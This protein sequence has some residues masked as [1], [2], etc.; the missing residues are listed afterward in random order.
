MELIISVSVA[1]IL[2]A[3]IAS[4]LVV[5]GHALP[6]RQSA[7][8][9]RLRVAEVVDR[10]AG[11][12][13]CALSVNTLADTIVEFTVADRDSDSLAETIRYAWAGAPG[14]PLTRQYNGGTVVSLLESV[15]GLG[16]AYDLTTVT[17]VTPGVSTD[18]PSTPIVYLD[19]D[20]SA[21]EQS[22]VV[23][24]ATWCGQLFELDA[25]TVPGNTTRWRVDDIFFRVKRAGSPGGITAAQLRPVDAGGRPTSIVYEQFLI[26]EKDLS[27]TNW[28]SQH[29]VVTDCPWLAPADQLSL[30]LLPSSGSNTC[31]VLFQATI[32]PAADNVS[33]LRTTDGG[34]S[35]AIAPGQAMTRFYLY[36]T[37]TTETPSE[38]VT[39]N[40]LRAVRITLQS[41]A[42][43]AT[44]A[45]TSV[46]ILNA[47]EVTP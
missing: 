18:Q 43:P 12:L 30:V 26:D 31:T 35:W 24:S 3:G 42:D 19:A 47:P 22:Y 44:R 23:S 9:K 6:N 10:M 27:A 37:I 4:S 32:V 34:S 1:G 17:E 2:L 16:L 39:Q 25:A 20:G 33:F 5:A 28:T 38:T 45:Q 41:E 14:D 36:G 13:Y 29:F 21:S 15:Q 40:W 7:A 46:Q 8:A 11:E